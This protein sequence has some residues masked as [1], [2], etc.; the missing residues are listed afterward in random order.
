MIQVPCMSVFC[1]PKIP[2]IAVINTIAM[3]Q[4]LLVIW[5]GNIHLLSVH[6]I[7]Q[8]HNSN[9]LLLALFAYGVHEDALERNCNYSRL[10]L[11][12]MNFHL[13]KE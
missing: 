1:K 2:G 3:L 12:K 10:K 6:E 8:M 4:L 9:V 5:V 7:I 11:T 13:N